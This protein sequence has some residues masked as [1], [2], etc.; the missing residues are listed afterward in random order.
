MSKTY[1]RR[2]TKLDNAVVIESFKPGKNYTIKDMAEIHQISMASM[3]IVIG[4]IEVSGK[5]ESCGSCP[6]GRLFRL[7]VDQPKFVTARPLDMK[8]MYGELTDRLKAE[9]AAIPSHMPK[10]EGAK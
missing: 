6:N 3:Q 9:R 1:T 8:K 2:S 4:L 5:I 7:K 10:I